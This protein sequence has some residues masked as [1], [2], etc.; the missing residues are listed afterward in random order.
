MPRGDRIYHGAVDNASGCAQVLAIARAFALLPERPRR[1]IM[2]L[3]VAG[4]ERGL[5]GSMYYAAASLRSRPAR[6]PPTSTSTAATSS[7]ARAT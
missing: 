6:S 2:A 4:E 3:F 7:G 1:S 5:L